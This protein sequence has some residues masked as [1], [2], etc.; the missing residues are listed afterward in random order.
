MRSSGSPDH[1]I[2][3]GREGDRGRIRAGRHAHDALEVPR[4]MALICKAALGRDRCGLASAIEEPSRTLHP[5]FEVVGV[6]SSAEAQ[7][8]RWND[9][10][11]GH[12]SLCWLD[13]TQMSGTT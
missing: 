11:A 9:G 13:D 7:G 5:A 6:R 2:T 8:D 12:V 1:P 3:P 10:I 4:E